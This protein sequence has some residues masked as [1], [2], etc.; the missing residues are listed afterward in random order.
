MKKFAFTEE[1]EIRANTKTL[2]QYLSTPNGLTSWFAESVTPSQ[3][4]KNILD[5]VWDSIHH[6]ARLT[7]N[8]SIGLVRYQFSGPTE[9]GQDPSFLEFK[10]NYSELTSSSFLKI[11]DFSEMSDVAELQSLW[12][13]LI[14]KLKSLVGDRSLIRA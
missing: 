2:L 13:G 6:Q 4:D 1:Y 3:T 12:E 14:Y 8:K 9:S 10:I 5:I 7:V 11:T